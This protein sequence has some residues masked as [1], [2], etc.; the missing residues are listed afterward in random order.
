MPIPTSRIVARSSS[1]PNPDGDYV[2]YWMIAA[3]RPHDNFALD[4]AL[5]LCREHG[6]PL[7]VFEPLRRGYRWACDRFHAFVQQGMHD[8][9]DAFEQAGVTYLPYVEP[10]DGDDKGLLA[11]LME[12][13]VAVVT[14]HYPTFFLRRMVDK[15]VGEAPVAMEVVDSLGIVPLADTPKVF[16][17][18][19]SFRRW[20]H[21]NLR[22]YLHTFPS[23]DPLEGYDLGAAKVPDLGDWPNGYQRGELC[24]GLGGPGVVELRGGHVAGRAQLDDFVANRLARYAEARNHPDDDAASGLSPWLHFGHVGAHRVVAEVLHRDH[25]TPDDLA[26]EPTGKREGWWG[27]SAEV[28]SFLDEVITWREVGHVFAHRVPDHDRYDTLPEWARTTLDEH[29]DDPRHAY[30][31]DELADAATDDPIWNAAQNQLRQTGVMHNYLRMLWGKKVLQWSPSPEE[32]VRRLIELNNRYALDG[33]DPNS[34]SGIF[35]VFGRFDRAWGP[36]RPI[37]GKVRYMTSESTKKKLHMSD[38]LERWTD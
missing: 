30:S 22:P 29:R 34:Y 11:A 17:V 33:R 31:L 12:R 9:H 32:A 1:A 7:L 21:K 28:E 16:T 26:D 25:W 37:F 14:D 5:E 20:L 10:S 18:A 6:K 24:L 13:A 35:W 4:R 2:L 23:S 38:Y 19:H 36:E 8:N 15:V 27:A 3:R